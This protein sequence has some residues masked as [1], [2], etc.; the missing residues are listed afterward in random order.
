MN[1]ILAAG[2][3]V[4]NTVILAY[5]SYLKKQ[6]LADTREHANRFSVH[7]TTKNK[8]GFTFTYVFADGRYGKVIVPTFSI[9]AAR[10]KVRE[11]FPDAWVR[12]RPVCRK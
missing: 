7:Y 3:K 5:G 11:Q 9:G 4:R 8:K 6:P 12:T 2:A 10:K 1:T